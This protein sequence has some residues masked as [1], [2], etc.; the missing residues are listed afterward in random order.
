MDT[1]ETIFI[2]FAALSL[3]SCSAL[4]YLLFLEWWESDRQYREKVV[5]LEQRRQ[6]LN[7]SVGRR[8]S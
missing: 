8:A 1:L 5:S 4:G 6:Q 3:L 7:A 2:A